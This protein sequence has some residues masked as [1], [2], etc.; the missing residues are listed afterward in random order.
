MIVTLGKMF[1]PISR[2]REEEFVARTRAG[3]RASDSRSPDKIDRPAR[4]LKIALGVALVGSSPDRRQRRDAHLTQPLSAAAS[5]RRT[6]LFV[7]LCAASVDR[8][9]CQRQNC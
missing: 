9:F 6:F 8:Y 5:T 4:R 2:L 1:A 7:L 3:K